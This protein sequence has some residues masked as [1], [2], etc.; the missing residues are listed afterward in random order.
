[1]I[2]IDDILVDDKILS[3]KFSCDLEKCKGACCTYKG[4]VGAPLFIEEVDK[5]KEN[6]NAAKKYLNQ[7]SIDIIEKEGFFD[8]PHDVLS[9]RCIE[10]KDCV[11]VFYENN[12]A[13]CSIEKAWHNGE[14][15]FRKPISCHL[16]PIRVGDYG[17][18]FLYY[19]NIS[20]CNPALK[21]GVAENTKL[22]ES[23]KDALKRAFGEEWTSKLIN[24]SK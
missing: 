1:M 8:N 22:S 3:S 6:L 14:S 23:V 15:D 12:V 24:K 2:L 10:K 4:E 19:E 7:N 20:Q 17:G 16:F 18:K 13:K 21:K 11:F 9:T 5:I